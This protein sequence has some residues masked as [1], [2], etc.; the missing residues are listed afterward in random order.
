MAGNILIVILVA[1][2]PHL[3]TPMYFFLGNLS[4]LETCYSS[5]ILP[6]MLASFLSGDR[7]ISVA[8]CL[9]QLYLFGVLAGTEC[10]FLAVMSYDRFLAICKPLH[11]AMLMNGRICIQLTVVSWICGSLGCSIVI[12]LV[13]RLN[14]CGPNKIDHFFCDLTPVVI[15]SCNDTHLVEIAAFI[16]ACIGT[17]PPLLITLA[18]YVCIIN[19]ILRIPSTTG[20]QKAFSTCSSHL[21]IVSCFYGSLMIVYVLPDISSLSE[22]KKLFSLFY[23]LLTPLLNP[24]IYSLRN[25][26]VKEAVRK[27]FR[28]LHRL[29]IQ[30]RRSKRKL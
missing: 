6:R 19:N 22:V 17:L 16:I 7:S 12:F 23:T 20:K 25:K 5:A 9:A 1:F 3:H 27:C 14:F 2:D 26:E 30:K 21:I 10:Y 11:Y 18:S 24:L 29:K 13:S 15:L 28:K 8:A 4:S